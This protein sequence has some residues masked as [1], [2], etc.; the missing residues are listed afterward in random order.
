WKSWYFSGCLIIRFALPL[1]I[2]YG[3]MP[4]LARFIRL[5]SMSWTELDL[6][7][8]L[9]RIGVPSG[10]QASLPLL[11]AVIAAHTATIPFENLD[12]VLGRPIRLDIASI[13][14]KLI[15]ANRGGYCFEQN[16]LLRAALER[17]GFRVSS[18]MARVVR[19]APAEA[20]TPRT[21]MLLRVNLP[22]GPYLADVGFGN[23][24]PT[25]PLMLVPDEPQPTGHEDYRVRPLEGETLLQARVGTA[26]ENV[27]RFPDLPSHPID[28]EV[29][30]WFTSTRPGGLFT[31]NVIAA[32]PGV[33][34]RKTLFN[35]E[36]TIRTLNTRTERSAPRTET[37][38]RDAL[39]D[40]F[41]IDLDAG[42]L[43]TVFAAMRQ[44]AQRREPGF[45]L[46]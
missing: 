25:A 36:V 21:H 42:D 18:L 2:L 46:D 32:R 9:A 41:G 31:A 16:T 44:F 19:T 1:P 35:G 15:H 17:L 39:H 20:I 24:T 37:A 8:Y 12:I 33:L 26:W 6:D 11:R 23:L 38:L 5:F 7:A 34:C 43:A 4:R 22:E 30:N 13:Q 3:M 27:Y 10:G 29:G 40:H 14:A 28:H 45:R